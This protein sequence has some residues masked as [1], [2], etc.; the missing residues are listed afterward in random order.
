MTA[1]LSVFCRA[2]ARA[3]AKPRPAWFS[4]PACLRSLFEALTVV[5]DRGVDVRA[6]VVS[7]GE[8]GADVRAEIDALDPAVRPEVLVRRGGSSRR[9]MLNLYDTALARIGHDDLVWFAEDDYV[10][11]PDA[12][13]HLVAAAEAV[14]ADY[15]ALHHPDDTAW[16]RSHPSQPLTRRSFPVRRFTVGRGSDD[17]GAGAGVLTWTT[18]THSTSTFGVRATALRR[19]RWLLGL[20]TRAGS[21]FAHATSMAVQGRAPFAWRRLG[22]DANWS[23]YPAQWRK[24]ALRAPMRAAV[25]VAAGHRWLV[26][27]RRPTLL[28]APEVDL[29]CHAEDG[30]VTDHR[31]WRVIAAGAGPRGAA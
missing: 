4:K 14:D 29:V 10:Y 25:N 8:I 1:P 22:A 26:G 31:D 16:H 21:P 7:D 12:F 3:N 15:L 30:F 20:A 9:S 27:R 5:A 18:V 23:R 6:V 17:A 24:S 19:D 2:T 28:V 13:V 11:A